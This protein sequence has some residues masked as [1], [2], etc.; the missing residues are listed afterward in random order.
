MSFEEELKK[1]ISE[2]P[3]VQGQDDGLYP[4]GYVDGFEEGALWAF[5]LCSDMKVDGGIITIYSPPPIPVRTYDWSAIRQG[6]DAGDHIG[7][8]ETEQ[9]AINDLKEREHEQP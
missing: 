8:G 2:I 5:E 4:E 9:Q 3:F 1:R 7:Y 6:Y